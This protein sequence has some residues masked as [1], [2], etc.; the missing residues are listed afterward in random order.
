MATFSSYI[1]QNNKMI[2]IKVIYKVDYDV[3]I[4]MLANYMIYI[5]RSRF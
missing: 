3:F 5:H 2:Q 4:S 1:T